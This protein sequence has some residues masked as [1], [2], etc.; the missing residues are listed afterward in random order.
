[1]YFSR[2]ISQVQ[3]SVCRH[4]VSQWERFLEGPRV[5]DQDTLGFRRCSPTPRKVTVTRNYPLLPLARRRLTVAGQGL[6]LDIPK[7]FF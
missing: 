2:V 5:R 4:S 6:S 7:L 3:K 1:M